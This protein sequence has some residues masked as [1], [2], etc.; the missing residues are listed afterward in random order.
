MSVH[1]VK[2]SLVNGGMEPFAVVCQGRIDDMY[3]F[4]VPEN[5][6]SKCALY[7]LKHP[8]VFGK[9]DLGGKWR[10]DVPELP[11]DQQFRIF[12]L[13]RLK[14]VETITLRVQK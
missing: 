3:V 10:I 4:V 9:D 2:S 13:A 7:V 11:A 1:L 6:Q 8:A 5:P 12:V 14:E